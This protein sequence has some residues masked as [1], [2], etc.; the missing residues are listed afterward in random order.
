MDTWRMKISSQKTVYCIFNKGSRKLEINLEYKGSQIK[1]DHNARFLGVYLDPGLHLHKHAETMATRALK[2][3]NMLRSIKGHNWGAS[4]ELIIKSYKVMIR[5]ILEYA[6][7]ATLV[8]SDNSRDKIEKVQRA[9]VRVATY[10]PI[11]TNTATMYGKFNLKSAVERAQEL[12]DNYMVKSMANN[13]LIQDTTQRYI[14][15]AEL[16]DGHHSKKP[17]PTPLGVL[18]L[19]KRTKSS[20]QLTSSDPVETRQVAPM[21]PTI[22]QD[23]NAALDT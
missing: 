20:Q 17:R 16:A 22:E 3:I 21:L 7:I 13:E 11:K 1:A 6:P 14:A 4:E 5:P 19:N 2:R 9:A 12:A 23:N 8:M 15:S 18:R 10:W